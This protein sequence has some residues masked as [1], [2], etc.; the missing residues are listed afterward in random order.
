MLNLALA[1]SGFAHPCD[2]DVRAQGRNLNRGVDR[3]LA[4]S[5]QVWREFQFHPHV[6]ELKLRAGQQAGSPTR[7]SAAQ[8]GQET[9]RGVRN[10]LANAELGGLAIRAADLWVLENMST[11]VVQYRVSNSTGQHGGEEFRQSTRPRQG[12][13]S[14]CSSG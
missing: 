12:A 8:R 9:A 5:E 1:K 7:R 14:R 2:G 13:Q 11:G 6:L 10:A 3:H 4:I